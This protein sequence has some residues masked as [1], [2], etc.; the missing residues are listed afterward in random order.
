ME[1]NSCQHFDEIRMIFTTN[2]IFKYKN[3]ISGV[4]GFFVPYKN[5][6][7]GVPGFFVHWFFGPKMDL[8]RG[9]KI[10][11]N[12]VNNVTDFLTFFF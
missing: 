9:H 11:K 1:P 5:H 8:K 12:R 4:P 7:F 3:H 10:R 6:I 2:V